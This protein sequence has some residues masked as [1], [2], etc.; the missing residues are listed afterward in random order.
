MRSP[1]T[2]YNDYRRPQSFL[3]LYYLSLGRAGG[4]LVTLSRD[5]VYVRGGEHAESQLHVAK[6]IRLIGTNKAYVTTYNSLL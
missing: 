4:N 6:C 5:T 2:G 1:S 3:T